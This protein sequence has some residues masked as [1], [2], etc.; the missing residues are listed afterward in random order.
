MAGSASGTQTEGAGGIPVGGRDRRRLPKLCAAAAAAGRHHS[1]SL[2]LPRG[3]PAPVCPFD[4][5]TSFTCMLVFGAMFALS[6][7]FSS[8]LF[9]HC[10]CDTSCFKRPALG[11]LSL[12]RTPLCSPVLPVSGGRT[13]VSLSL[14][15]SSAAGHTVATRGPLAS[16]PSVLRAQGGRVQR[17]GTGLLPHQVTGQ[18]PPA[19]GD[20]T[21]NTGTRSLGRDGTGRGQTCP[22]EAAMSAL[23]AQAELARSLAR[24]L[25][26]PPRTRAD[27]VVP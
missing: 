25:L 12:Q 11:G 27:G 7:N 2:I 15:S 14:P 13:D 9:L 4:L 10:C 19:P 18:A 6:L 16:P 26:A 22:P 8:L 21:I 20:A 24:Q 23:P 5:N 17:T 3:C 1:S